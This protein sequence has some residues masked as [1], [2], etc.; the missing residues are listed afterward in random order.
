MYT[1]QYCICIWKYCVCVLYLV[2][3]VFH[4]IVSNWVAFGAFVFGLYWMLQSLCICVF[5][6]SRVFVFVLKSLCICVL[7]R[8]RAL[9][10][11]RAIKL[12]GRQ[13]QMSPVQLQD[14]NV[15]YIKVQKHIW[16]KKIRIRWKTGL[17]QTC[18]CVSYSFSLSIS[19][20]IHMLDEKIWSS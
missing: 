3:F 4:Y 16:Q 19:F 2:W 18:F 9:W 14:K 5:Y 10:S 11:N 17:K 8:C 13:C 1:V 6:R 20:D 12:Q 15:E 7:Y